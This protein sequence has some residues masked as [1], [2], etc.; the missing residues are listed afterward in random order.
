[1]DL[2]PIGRTDLDWGRV[3]GCAIV[4]LSAAGGCAL[5]GL[6]LWTVLAFFRNVLILFQGK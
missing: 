3:A 5:V 1:M 2:D 4:G 6:L